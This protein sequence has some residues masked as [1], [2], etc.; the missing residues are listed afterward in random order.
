MLDYRGSTHYR[1]I[2]CTQFSW[3]VVVTHGE[4]DIQSQTE[5]VEDI[6]NGVLFFI[7]PFTQFYQIV[8]FQPRVEPGLQQYIMIACIII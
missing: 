8:Y 6:L 5:L 7:Q 3:L 4:E 1:N 2:A